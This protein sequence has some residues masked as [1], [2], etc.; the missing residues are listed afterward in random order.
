MGSDAEGKLREFFYDLIK[1][2]DMQ[3]LIEPQFKFSKGIQDA[4]TGL[5]GIV[6]SHVSF[7][8]WT[9]Q[10]YI[11]LDI[12]SCKPFDLKTTIKFLIKFWKSEDEKV[13]FINR[14]EK[15]SQFIVNHVNCDLLVAI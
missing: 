5:L 2:I 8:Y 12:Y 14:D 1:V 6:T 9:I 10:Q 3:V 7:H 15:E 4:W 11:Q 13:L